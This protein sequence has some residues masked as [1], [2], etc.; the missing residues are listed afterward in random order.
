MSACMVI[1]VTT[2]S[3]VW[4]SFRQLLKKCSFNLW[5]R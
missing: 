3:K 2:D 4:R 1:F 5:W